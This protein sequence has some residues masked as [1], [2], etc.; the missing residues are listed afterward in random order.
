MKNWSVVFLG[1]IFT[2]LL[3]GC[4]IEEE[5]AAPTPLPPDFFTR[6]LLASFA[7]LPEEVPPTAYEMTEEIVNL[8]RML[9]YED[10]ISIS[11]ELSC[12]SCHLLDNYGVDGL[13]FSLGHEGIPV[14]RNSPTVYNAALHI[15]QFWD[16]REPDVEAQAKG[17]ILAAGEMG[18]PNPEYVV[19]VLNTIPGYVELFQEA[20]PG[21]PD[22][23]NYDNVGTVIGAF[24]RRLMTPDRFD[25][26]LN[27][28]DAALNDQEKR[29]VALFVNTGCTT[30]HYG[31]AVGGM[32]YAVLG[33]AV[34]YDLVVDEGR[35]AITG[36]E[37][38][39]HSFKVP[40]LRNIAKT[41][42]YLHDG[43]INTLEEMVVLMAK[44]QLDKELTEAQVADIVA[45][46]N[47]MTGELP[48]DYIAVPEFPESGPDTPLPYSFEE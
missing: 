27:G 9:Y 48:M 23:I 41:G 3:A 28:D 10:R 32:R 31:A 39:M 4:A 13:Q 24:E 2:L 33:Q 6:D 22:P 25:D 37:A 15:S 45:F 18:M 21:D 11:Q 46:L 43:S 12:N 40:S 19:Q 29:G 20:F 35:F 7:P 38:D 16:G 44:H 26:L 14:G 36:D 17:P 34:P 30:C 5:A 1:V 42:P 47:A 8:G